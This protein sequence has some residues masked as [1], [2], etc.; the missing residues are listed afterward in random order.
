MANTATGA[1]ATIGGQSKM[2]TEMWWNY[3]A[4]SSVGAD[5]YSITAEGTVGPEIDLLLGYYFADVDPKQNSATGGA[6]LI[7]DQYEIAEVA[8]TVSK[9]FGPLDTSIALIWDDY[10]NQ[11]SGSTSDDDETVTTLQVYLTYNF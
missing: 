5:S 4:V 7:E 8:F 6:V 3:G 9:S 11:S 1:A 10:D 2:Y